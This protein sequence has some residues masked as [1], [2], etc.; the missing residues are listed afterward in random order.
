MTDSGCEDTAPSADDLPMPA[1]KMPDESDA[2]MRKRLFNSLSQ[3]FPHSQ[4]Y[5]ALHGG[6][7]IILNGGDNDNSDSDDDSL[8][9]DH[10]SNS[11]FASL[12][13]DRRDSD[14]I[15]DDDLQSLEWLQS[16]DLLK[17][18]GGQ[19]LDDDGEEQ[20]E[21]EDVKPDINVL[22]ANMAGQQ[23]AVHPYLP[24]K[25]VNSKPPYSF[26]CLIFMAVENSPKK[27]LPVKDIYNWILKQFPYFQNAPTGWKNSVRHNLSLNKC[28]K[29]VEKDKGQSI[30]KGSLWCID[31][32]YRPNLLQAL[33]KTPYHPYHQLQMTSTQ[34][35]N[36]INYNMQY[37]CLPS[38]GRTVL[39]LTQRP[40]PN[41]VSPH[42][43]PFLSRRLAQTSFDI[44]S[45]IKD[46]AQ[47]L[48]ALKTSFKKETPD[49]SP[50]EDIGPTWKFHKSSYSYN[51]NSRKRP[52]SPVTVTDHPCTD[53][54]YSSSR[55]LDDDLPSSSS[56]SI[57]EE[58]DFG[59]ADDDGE[60]YDSE[61]DSDDKDEVDGDLPSNKR[62]KIDMDRG[63]ET[64]KK[65]VSESDDDDEEQKKIHEG[66]N[67]L[68]NLAGFLLGNRSSSNTS[69]EK[70]DKEEGEKPSKKRLN[71]E[72]KKVKK[73]KSVELE[74]RD[75]SQ[76]KSGSK[77]NR[78][79]SRRKNAGNNGKYDSDE[80]SL[81]K[82]KKSSS[83]SMKTKTSGEP[84][85]ASK[86]GSSKSMS[87]LSNSASKV[88]DGLNKSKKKSSITKK[89]LKL[90]KNFGVK[91]DSPPSSKGSS[92]L[93]KKSSK[94]KTDTPGKKSSKKAKLKKDQDD[95]EIKEAALPS[96][97]SKV[98]NNNNNVD[99][100]NNPFSVTI[101]DINQPIKQEIQ[102]PEEKAESSQDLQPST[103]GFSTGDEPKSSE[104]SPER[105][106]CRS[107]SQDFLA[108]MGLKEKHPKE[109]NNY[110][111]ARNTT[112]KNGLYA[113]SLP[114]STS[115]SPVAAHRSPH[116]TRFSKKK[117]L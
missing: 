33:R 77:S 79:T 4:L 23:P 64:L 31:P 46:V 65:T 84:K 91:K 61:W 12:R 112:S 90:S 15:Y 39:P 36:Y 26:S 18:I 107:L 116:F 7:D 55:L 85:S 52:S 67:A 74:K 105:S 11:C 76:E 9:G 42:L 32:A 75:K 57:D 41:T 98:N 38:A 110:S 22:N 49:S 51:S 20:K 95:D 37:Q 83:G 56:S 14:D 24:Q 63:K 111:V 59:D 54:T 99:K 3:S 21:N 62:L 104:D 103:P 92:L 73:K 19:K 96:D 47:T 6:E 1:I 45:D 5:K 2:T 82:P 27:M 13:M 108:A 109:N 93:S 35:P 68:L 25:H 50:A 30:G 10:L 78:G 115:G 70:D 106:A 114:A 94:N 100:D 8:Y 97:V 117:K 86:P 60:S 17:N 69:N 28:F 89:K 80:Y 48:V 40:I 58:Y 81:L 113:R 72:K 66:A 53:H 29:K 71:S 88:K 43:F 34:P 101:G 87:D 44:D 16:E 102:S